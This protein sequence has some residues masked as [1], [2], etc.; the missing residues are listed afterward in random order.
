[1]SPKAYPAVICLLFCNAA[2]LT[3]VARCLVGRFI[4]RIR[5]SD[6]RARSNRRRRSIDEARWRDIE[7]RADLM[8][9]IHR[10][11]TGAA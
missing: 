7:R 9:G 11:L 1:M 8:A 5:E 3:V 10:K 6:E 2:L 4:R